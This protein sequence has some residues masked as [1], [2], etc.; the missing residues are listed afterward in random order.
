MPTE[1][2]ES[3]AHRLQTALRSRLQIGD[4]VIA[5]SVSIGVAVGRPGLD[6]IEDLLR[7]ADGAVLT[8]KRAGGN[9]VAVSSDAT[10]LNSVFRNDVERHLPAGIDSNALLLR[11]LRE[12]DLLTGAILG[13][14]ALVRWRHPTRG[15]LLPD[16]FIGVA[17]S[18]NLVEELGRWVT[19][20][21]CA[22]FSRWRSRGVGQNATLRINV[23]PAQLTASGF[24][25]DVADIIH[26]FGIDADSVCLEITERAVTLPLSVR[27]LPMTFFDHDNH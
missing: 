8:A 26:E 13:A 18:T 12:V 20:T 24:V 9:Q 21:A 1:T 4:D 6:N 16:S 17:E 14:E 10:S 7:R 22:E 19:R 15:L 23:S 5:P 25:S 3:L 11:Y 2:A 27:L